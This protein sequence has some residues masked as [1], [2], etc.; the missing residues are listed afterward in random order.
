M[1]SALFTH[2][3]RQSGRARRVL[4]WIVMGILCAVLAAFWPN[5]SPGANAQ[6]SYIAVIGLATVRVLALASAIMT[7]AVIGQEV[8]GRTIVYLLTRPIPRPVLLLVRFAASVVVVTLLGL[9]AF[10]MTSVGAHE[11]IGSN[12]LLLRDLAVV[13]LGALSYGALFLFVSLVV[14]RAL[15]LCVLFAFGWE[16]AVPNMPGD[17]Y[18]ASILSHLQAAMAHPVGKG[19]STSLLTGGRTNLISPTSGVVTMLILSAALLALSAWWFT[20]HEY[21]PREDAE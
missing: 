16:T 7:T 14:N 18:R 12:P 3:L 10:F 11:G 1:V 21:I 17:I 6:E 19:A 9:F 8:E 5:F 15:I 13:A 2:A 20:T 4:P